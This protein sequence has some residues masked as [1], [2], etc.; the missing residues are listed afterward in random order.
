MNDKL[1]LS[2]SELIEI[3]GEAKHELEVRNVEALED[4][5]DGVLAIS[6]FLTQ[7]GLTKVLSG[8]ART[9]SVQSILGGLAR[10]GGRAALDGRTM[11]QNSLE[12]AELVDLVFKK[13]AE[14]F[15]DTNRDPNIHEPV[16]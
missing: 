6:N 2:E 7:G 12:I 4:L 14:R 3:P 16:E 10:H 13:C 5:A 9:Q 8:Y 11:K 1:I 15:K